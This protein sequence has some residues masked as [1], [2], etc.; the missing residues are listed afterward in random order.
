MK[1]Q[2]VSQALPRRSPTV[3]RVLLVDDDR[4]TREMY[5]E[6]LR[7]DGFELRTASNGRDAIRAARTFLPSVIVTDLRLAGS[8]DGVELTRQ[9]RADIRT[10]EIRIIMLTGVTFGDERER[11]ESSGVDAFVIKPC[12]PNRLASE[13]RRVS[14][15]ESGVL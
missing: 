13:I 8:I 2:A 5:C 7:A 12:L 6:C 3:L 1:S 15:Q 9:L 14:R 11:A 10:G 4:D